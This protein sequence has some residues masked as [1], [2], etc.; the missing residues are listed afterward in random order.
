MG[1]PLRVAI[2][3]C[4]GI[5]RAHLEA[6]KALPVTPVV[7]VDVDEGRARQYAQQY[8]ALRHGTRIEDALAGDVDAVIICLPH[9]LDREAVVAAADHGKHVLTEKPMALSLQEAD[10][11]IAT[12]NHSLNSDASAWDTHIT[13]TAGSMVVANE[14]IVL[15]EGEMEVPMGPAIERQLREFV[16]AIAGEREPDASGAIVRRT[17]QALEAAKLS[18]ASGQVISTGGM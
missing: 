16:D 6:M 2:I 15:G 3:G 5:T 14:R 11:A 17:M 12:L 4:G 1:S 8:A 18:M 13:G 10:A 7:T 9:H